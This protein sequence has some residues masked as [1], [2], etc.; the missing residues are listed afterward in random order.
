[1][2]RRETLFRAPTGAEPTP[3]DE[4]LAIALANVPLLDTEI[5]PLAQALGRTLLAEVR[6]PLDVPPF[7][8]SAMDGYAVR[9]EDTQGASREHPRRLTLVEDVPAGALPR[10]RV[11]AGEATRIMTGAPLP[12]GADAV[13]RV[14]DT[15]PEEGQVLVLCAVAAGTD[16]RPAGEDVVKGQVAIEGGRVV[17]SAEAGMLAALGFK[18]VAVAR[19]PTVALITTGEELVRPGEELSPGQIYNCNAHSLMAQV[20]EAGAEVVSTLHCGD[21]AKALEEALQAS[22]QADVVLASGAVSAGLQDVVRDFI[23]ERGEVH[24]YRVAMRPGFPN[25]FATY[26]G[27]PFF[28]VPG[29]PVSSMVV[30]EVLVRPALLRMQGRKAIH[31][32]KVTS[33][34]E[35]GTSARRGFREFLRARTVFGEEGYRSRLVGPQGSGRLSTMVQANSLVVVPE[36]AAVIEAGESVSVL[37]TDAKETE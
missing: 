10:K 2:N 30:F 12:A 1:M 31:R 17:R 5:A 22:L 3:V 16:V 14:E 6:A 18:E 13:V 4:A 11:E 28:G 23:L 37:L 34:L 35:E 29:N 8:N 15:E 21:E 36:E 27:K 19:R 20:Q 26:G 33:V 9:A 32:P 7:A 25:L 24:F